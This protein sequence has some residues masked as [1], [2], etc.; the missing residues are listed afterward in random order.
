MNPKKIREIKCIPYPKNVKELQAFLGVIIFYRIFLPDVSALLHPL[1]NFLRADT[2]FIWKHSCSAAVKSLLLADKC[3][4]HFNPNL[5][6]KLTM[7]ASS[8]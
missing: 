5:K 3:L 4:A 6:I 2:K 1:H 7:V 8:I